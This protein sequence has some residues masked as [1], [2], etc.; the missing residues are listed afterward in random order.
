MKS[1]SGHKVFITGVNG[2]YA[3]HLVACILGHY[4]DCEILGIDIKDRCVDNYKGKYISCDITDYNSV[5]KIVRR[6]QP[7]I[8]FHLAGI[9]DERKPALLYQNNI[10]GSLNV[11]NAICA[12]RKNIRIIL[13]SSCAVYA[14]ADSGKKFLSEKQDICPHS[15]YG[16]SKLAMELLSLSCAKEYN[17]VEVIIART[18]NL[19]GRGI[20]AFLLPG[21]LFTDIT[22]VSKRKTE[23]IVKLG[24][25]NTV[26]DFVDVRDAAQALVSL[27]LS[28][29]KNN[30][31]NIGSGKG[32]RVGNLAGIFIEHIDPEVKVSIEPSLFKKID[33]GVI[34]ADAHKIRMHTGWQA[35]FSLTDSVGYTIGKS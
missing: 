25:L 32:V 28:G 7:D 30:V 9:F 18:F 22:R 11:M 19:I 3:R 4:G 35:R 33:P 2:F 10:V 31:Y 20:S 16:I 34:I 15:H 5:N 14:K 23:K 6:F 24:N 26:R 21:K 13:S 12:M 27:A 29:R 17:C 8:V 1:L